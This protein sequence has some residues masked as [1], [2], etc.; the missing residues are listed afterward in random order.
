LV[1]RR[2]HRVDHLD[3]DGVLAGACGS[4]EGHSFFL[5][6]LLSLEFFPASLILAYVVRD[7]RRVAY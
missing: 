1:V 2:V 3:R 5:F 7:R 4:A 6:F